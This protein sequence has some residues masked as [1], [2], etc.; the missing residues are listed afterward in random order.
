MPYFARFNANPNFAPEQLNGYELGYRRLFGS[1]FYID[2]SGFYNHYHGLFDEEIVGGA[3]LEDTPAPPHVLLPAQ[4]G[5]G[6]YG[7]SK[8]VEVAPDWSIRSFWRLRGSYS[9][10]HMNIGRSPASLD[11]GTAPGIVGASPQHQ[12]AIQSDFDLSKTI[13]L[14]LGYRY[15]SSLPGQLVSGYSTGNVRLAWHFAPQ[16]EIALVGDNLLQPRHFEFGGD[17]GP[18]V[19]IR[20]SAYAKIT[21]SR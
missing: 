19:G 20:R 3:F 10:L 13:Q 2:L 17:P 21:W 7:Y 8:G 12:V 16:F 15:V 11:V 4:F 1:K 18:L 14:D 5:N 6:L 9:F